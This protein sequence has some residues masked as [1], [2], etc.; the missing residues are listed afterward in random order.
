[1]NK[2]WSCLAIGCALA[3]LGPQPSHADP[4]AG[5]ALV[6]ASSTGAETRAWAVAKNSLPAGLSVL[7]GVSGTQLRATQLFQKLY[8]GLLASNRDARDAIEMTKA[9]CNIDL[10]QSIDSLVIGLQKH[11]KGVFVIGLNGVDR[12]AVTSCI[13]KLVS[14]EDA[15]HKLTVKQQGNINEYSVSGEKDKLYAAWLAKDV[16]A[17]TTD[18]SD[19]ALLKKLTAGG[20][21]GDSIGKTASSLKTDAALWAVTTRSEFFPELGE[22][23]VNKAYGTTNFQ[24]G[25]V[26]VNGHVILDTAAHATLAAA[27]ISSQIDA[28]RQNNPLA[29]GLLRN[30]SVSAVGQDVTVTGNFVESD[31][32]SL[33]GL[34]LGGAH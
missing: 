5:F 23:K 21:K 32:A 8:P 4:R 3:V 22:A 24:G 12:D 18:P 34:F 1:M 11:D 19:K 33:A 6:G 16:V 30:V 17:V 27:R 10:V 28:Q 15:S 26:D 31:L 20:L 14:A 2:R 7:V 25:H 29:G 9:R 13:G